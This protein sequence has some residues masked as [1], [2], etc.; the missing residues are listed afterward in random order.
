MNFLKKIAKNYRIVGADDWDT[1]QVRLWI[2][3]DEGL[4]NDFKRLNPQSYREVE[5]WLEE[6]RDFFEGMKQKVDIDAVDS[7]VLLELAHDL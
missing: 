1:E 6:H 5:D 2:L 7:A 3:N 4:Y